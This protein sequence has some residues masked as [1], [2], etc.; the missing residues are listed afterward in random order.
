MELGLENSCFYGRPLQ[1]LIAGFTAVITSIMANIIYF[2]LLD[3]LVLSTVQRRSGPY[4]V[5]W[6]GLIQ[7]IDDGIKL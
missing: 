7:S 6:F 3:R 2:L 1:L 4:I 5:G